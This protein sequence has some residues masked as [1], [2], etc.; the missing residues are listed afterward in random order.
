MFERKR[1]SSMMRIGIISWLAFVMLLWGGAFAFAQDSP[2]GSDKKPALE[3]KESA[4]KS[5]KKENAPANAEEEE[6]D[7]LTKIFGEGGMDLTAGTITSDIDPETNELKTMHIVTGVKIISELMNVECDD[8]LIDMANQ[9][10]TAKGKIVNFKMNDVEGTCG[11]LTYDM[12][13]KRTLLEGKPKPLIRQKDAK[14]RITQTS[15]NIITMV[16]NDK[17]NNVNWEGNVEFKVIPPAEEKKEKTG[18]EKQ[19]APQKI[20]AGSVSKI[21]APSSEVK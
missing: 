18:D 21:R 5:E 4:D 17:T 6:E 10:M 15:A 14:G 13:S 12:E 7:P 8:L 20:D 3:K 16:Q 9:T 1:A 19:E 11:R 2:A